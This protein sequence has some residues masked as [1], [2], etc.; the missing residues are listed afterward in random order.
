M[1][2]GSA[3]L[4]VCH[5]MAHKLGSH[6]GIPHG[7]ANA[8]LIS[9]VILYNSAERPFKVAAFPQYTTPTARADYAHLADALGLAASA[10]H[11]RNGRRGSGAAAASGPATDGA[12]VLALVAA[13]EELKASVGIA[14][15]VRDVLGA[16]R[17]AEYFAALPSLAE[18]SFD[19]QCTG[20][21]PRYPLIS[22]LHA[23]L[24]AAWSPLEVPSDWAEGGAE[25]RRHAAAM[26][27]EAGDK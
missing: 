21:N 16:D 6:F 22:D 20:T 13:V 12:K 18:K 11:A 7:L 8:L 26:A 24:A 10:P 1:A 27:V 15:S 23:M 25:G 9:H 4:G 5:S 19:D 3:F 2:F 17:E 14:R